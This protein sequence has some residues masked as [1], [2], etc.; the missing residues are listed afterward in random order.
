MLSQRPLRGT[1]AEGPGGGCGPA[2]AA[3]SLAGQALGSAEASLVGVQF[4]PFQ[5][6]KWEERVG[7]QAQAF[8]HS[9]SE[10]SA[11]GLRLLRPDKGGRATAARGVCAR[12]KPRAAQCGPARR[13]GLSCPLIFPRPTAGRSGRTPRAPRAGRSRSRTDEGGRAQERPEPVPPGWARTAGRWPTLPVESDAAR[14]GASRPR[15]G[16]AGGD[17]EVSTPAPLRS[18]PTLHGIPTGVRGR[19]CLRGH[20]GRCGVTASG[21][22]PPRRAPGL[23]E[24]AGSPEST[25]GSGLPRT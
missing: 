23:C 7:A 18:S 2:A 17:S 9:R 6:R 20:F 14:C 11:V 5:K 19:C 16:V 24:R 3:V 4:S 13:G 12:T 21:A 25:A 8:D 10:G 15:A 1:H 22:A